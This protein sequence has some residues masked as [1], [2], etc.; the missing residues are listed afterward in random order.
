MN[1]KRAI[2]V[3][4]ALLATVTLVLS[5]CSS[6]VPQADYSRLQD[7]ID[8]IQFQLNQA[9]QAL[10]SLNATSVSGQLY[11]DLNGRY[12][13]LESNYQT[14]QAEQQKLTQDYNQLKQNDGALVSANISINAGDVEQLLFNMINQERTQNGLKELA[15]GRN[16]YDYAIQN[17]HNMA[18]NQS[19]ERSSYTS[20]QAVS[21]ATGYRTSADMAGAVMT[22][23]KNELQY[24]QNFFN[25]V[26]VYGAVAVYQ[27]GDIYYVT[28]IAS[29]FQ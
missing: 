28:F 3:I 11:Q 23:W 25:V 10:V 22:I 13:I 4:A 29:Q 24:Q 21:W 12:A 18:A 27:S 9:Q 14:L 8:Q 15:W 5:A 26:A 17:N 20:W 7:E 2:T 16:L 19:H 1:K 6:G